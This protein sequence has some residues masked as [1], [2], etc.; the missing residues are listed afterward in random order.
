[1]LG[2]AECSAKRVDRVANVL[3]CASVACASYSDEMDAALMVF[4]N[5]LGAVIMVSV[6]GFHYLTAKPKDAEL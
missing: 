3:L 2:R 5:C 6:V 4:V 1:M